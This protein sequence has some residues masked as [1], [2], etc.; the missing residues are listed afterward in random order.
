MRAPLWLSCRIF[1]RFCMLNDQVQQRWIS[2]LPC[3]QPSMSADTLP[4]T[5]CT[6]RKIPLS[7]YQP[8]R[9]PGPGHSCT[10]LGWIMLMFSR[11]KH[12]VIVLEQAVTLWEN[13]T[14]NKR[15]GRAKRILTCSDAGSCYVQPNLRNWLRQWVHS[16]R[17]FPTGK[18]FDKRW[19]RLSRPLFVTSVHSRKAGNP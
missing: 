3:T 13:T 5:N 14:R 19:R 11:L 1:I 12:T 7:S 9:V 15:K 4:E 10:R 17:Q 6:N 8:E 16:K 2:E 18:E